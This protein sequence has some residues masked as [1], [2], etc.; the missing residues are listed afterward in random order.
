M[1]IK[2]KAPNGAHVGSAKKVKA[3]DPISRRPEVWSGE[4]ADRACLQREMR[5]TVKSKCL[6]V[7]R[8]GRLSPK[9]R[10][11]TLAKVFRVNLPASVEKRAFSA[12]D[13]SVSPEPEFSG[14]PHRHRRMQRGRADQVCASWQVSSARAQRVLVSKGPTERLARLRR[15]F[16]KLINH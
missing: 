5:T 14:L 9:T 12:T 7:P 15:S 2:L 8:P 16:I 4:A 6:G 1:P 3:P 10:L 13:R 11:Q